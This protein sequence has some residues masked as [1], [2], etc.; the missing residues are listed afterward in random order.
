METI[1]ET[2]QVH[3]LRRAQIFL[4]KF[5]EFTFPRKWGVTPDFFC[6]EKATIP[7]FWEME[8]VLF[9]LSVRKVNSMTT[10]AFASIPKGTNM[11]YFK[12]FKNKNA[13]F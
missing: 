6:R 11:F 3:G 7:K 5:F 13:M 10:Q 12:I 8:S 2:V 4:G 1:Y 9:S